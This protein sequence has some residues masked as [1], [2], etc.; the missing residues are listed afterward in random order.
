VVPIVQP[1]TR[2]LT[3][4][5]VAALFRC[6]VRS[7]YSSGWPERLR[8]VKVGNK[9]LVPAVTVNEVLTGKR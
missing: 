7:L 5:E 4:P 2:M 1:E 3:L 6:S 9:W 8:A